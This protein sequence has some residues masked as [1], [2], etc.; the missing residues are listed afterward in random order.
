MRLL[1]SYTSIWLWFFGHI[2]CACSQAFLKNPVSKLASNWFGDKERGFATAIGLVSTPLGILVSLILI[3]MIFRSDDRVAADEGG[4]SNE[5]TKGRFDLYMTIHS[6]MTIGMAAPALF[7][8]R[9]KPPSPPSM[10]AIKSR[11]V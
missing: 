3:L 6:I 10:V 9:E 11:P 2:V 4:P 1:S 7:L 5:D 8:I